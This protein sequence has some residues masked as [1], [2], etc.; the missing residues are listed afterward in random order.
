MSSPIGTPIASAPMMKPNV[1]S[2]GRAASRPNHTSRPRPLVD[3]PQ[4]DGSSAEQA[5]GLDDPLVAHTANAGELKQPRDDGPD[6]DRGEHDRDD[7]R[8]TED[9]DPPGWAE[10]PLRVVEDELPIQAMRRGP[11]EPAMAAAIH[12]LIT[13]SAANGVTPSWMAPPM[14]PVNNDNCA[15]PPR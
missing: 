13:S 14:L 4:R 8:Q 6:E 10:R 9:G 3:H 15:M 2:D 11:R 12:A 7:R 5:G 1:R